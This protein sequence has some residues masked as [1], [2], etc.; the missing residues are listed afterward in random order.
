MLSRGD[1]QKDRS[2]ERVPERSPKVLANQ[3]RRTKSF[4]QLGVKRGGYVV[5]VRKAS[6]GITAAKVYSRK[7]DCRLGEFH[8]LCCIKNRLVRS[9]SFAISP[10]SLSSLSESCAPCH[11]N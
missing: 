3:A 2:V 11:Q 10:L 6:Y 9:L 8:H 5:Y 4:R 1:C 7:W